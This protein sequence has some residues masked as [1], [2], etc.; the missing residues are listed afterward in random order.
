M[1]RETPSVVGPDTVRLALEA[2]GQAMFEFDPRD[3]KVSW[4]DPSQVQLL[5]GLPDGVETASYE[6][7]ANMV[8]AEDAMTRASELTRARSEGRAYAVEYRITGADGACRWLE[9]RGVWMNVGG[10]ERLVGMI[11]PID[12]QKDREEQ[13]NYLAAHDEMTGQ[14]NRS[15]TKGAIADILTSEGSDRHYALFLVAIDNIGSI[16]VSFGF[17]AADQ[18]ISI[19]GQRLREGLDGEVVC[20][21]VAGTKFAVVASI[22]TREDVR[23]RAIE[24]MNLIRS[25][26][27]ETRAGA[28]A[29]SVCLGVTQLNTDVE[30]ADIAL[31][32]AEAALDQARVAGPSSWS[33]FAETKEAH[34]ARNRDVEMS[35]V[36]LSALND[37]RVT[38]AYQPIVTDL[39]A[40]HKK[41]ECL[42]RLSLEDGSE[43]SAPSFVAAAERLGLVHLLDRRVLELAMISLARE[44]NIQLAVN[45][46]WET[47]KDPVWADGYIAHLRANAHL[48][49]RLTVELTETRIVDAVEASEEFVSRIKS[50]GAKF[51][52]DDFG[53]GY[54]SFRNLKALDIDILKIDGSFITGLA[55]S[56]ENQLFVRTLIDL[57]RNFGMQTVA[58]WVDNEQDAHMLKALGVN[59]LQGFYV[60]KPEARPEWTARDQSADNAVNNAVDKAVSSGG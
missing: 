27:V 3:E 23:A 33:Q 10:A 32:R 14:L 59:Y 11:R 58:E 43:L 56:R 55:Q 9:E 17:D 20:G 16:N 37:R 1:T 48:A 31:A 40:E 51:A 7:I 6:A 34:S 5:L 8:T 35:D 15:R 13:L 28:I 42:I 22:E 4:A 53:A 18:V 50:L 45:V 38:V 57:A 54:T 30:S 52:L 49:E 46:S 36:I 12:A 41:F 60:G 44:P 25:D 2:A 39:E 19:V 47:V 29:V 24:I 26:V 21:R